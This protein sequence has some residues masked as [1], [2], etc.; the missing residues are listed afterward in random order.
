MNWAQVILAVA[1]PLAGL[2]GVLLGAW[3]ANRQDD[4][5]W[6]LDTK[7]LLYVQIARVGEEL[8]A[9][10]EEG[11]Y[12]DDMSILRR[13]D[14]DVPVLLRYLHAR[15]EFSLLL[16]QAAVVAG[17]D[18]YNAAR[19]YMVGAETAGAEV[20]TEADPGFWE[21]TRN[22]A[23]RYWAVLDAMRADLGLGPSQMHVGWPG[24]EALMEELKLSLAKAAKADPGYVDKKP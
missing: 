11:L 21:E 20:G 13:T 14:K 18:V 1:A 15:D 23:E 10:V 2:A 7:H 6:R 5:R 4:R 24:Q 12:P 9:C 8:R 17:N 22:L 16:P 19:A 3:A